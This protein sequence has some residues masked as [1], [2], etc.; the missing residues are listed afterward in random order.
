MDKESHK[1]QEKEQTPLVIGSYID[2]EQKK[3]API[4]CSQ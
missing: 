1:D 4:K 3:S 2:L